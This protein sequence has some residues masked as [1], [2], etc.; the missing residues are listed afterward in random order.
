M[1]PPDLPFDPEQHASILL[2]AKRQI[3]QRMRATR[4]A[5]PASVVAQKSASIC[6]RLLNLPILTSARAIALFAP[7]RERREVDLWMLDEQMRASGKILFYPF[8]DPTDSGYRTGFRRVDRPEDLAPRDQAFAEPP[9]DA[10]EARRGDI[11]VV[12]VP[13]LAAA[14]DGHRLGYGLGYYDATLPDVVPPARSVIVVFDFQLLAELPTEPH[15]HP[16]D[17]IVTER[18]TMEVAARPPSHPSLR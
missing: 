8:L 13:A 11:D 10:P 4:Q 16:C 6:E 9:S 3:R 15:D 2:R 12:L 18:R 5:Y 1:T 17:W 14:A 7:I